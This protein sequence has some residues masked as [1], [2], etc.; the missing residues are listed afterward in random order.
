[1]VREYRRR[2]NTVENIHN[3]IGSWDRVL[4]VRETDVRSNFR[5]LLSQPVSEIFSL[6][7]VFSHLRNLRKRVQ[8][9]VTI[10]QGTC[11]V[12][13]TK[14]SPVRRGEYLDGWPN[15]NPPCSNNL[16]S[17][18][19]FPLPF[20]KAI[21]KT[22]ELSSLRNIVSSLYQLWFLVSPWPYLCV[23][24]CIIV[25]INSGTRRSNYPQFSGLLTFQNI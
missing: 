5:S 7:D 8:R 3:V 24:I 19:F 6:F 16:F 15:S 1:M 13:S 11:F 22:V 20:S 2:C 17:F 21:L 9:R 25:F 12:R 14:L 4:F 23:F 18:P 10:P